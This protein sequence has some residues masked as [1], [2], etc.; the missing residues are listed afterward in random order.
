MGEMEE[1]CVFN[2]VAAGKHWLL[3]S[4]RSNLHDVVCFDDVSM[5]VLLGKYVESRQPIIAAVFVANV[6]PAAFLTS[7][8]RP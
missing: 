6:K 7:V 5:R 4:K 2:I 3:Q 8:I 1:P